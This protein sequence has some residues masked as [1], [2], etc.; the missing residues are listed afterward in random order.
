MKNSSQYLR[1]FC[2]PVFALMLGWMIVGCTVV[3]GRASPSEY[4]SDTA[5]TTQ[6]KAKIVQNDMLSAANIHVET[7]K[8]VVQ[9][10]G[11]VSKDAQRNE[12]QRLA[13]TVNGVRSVVNTLV[14]KR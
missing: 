1:G 10:S 4:V 12:A 6:L 13:Y 11:F 3:Q 5:I 8:G 14:V 7:H 9:L 2:A